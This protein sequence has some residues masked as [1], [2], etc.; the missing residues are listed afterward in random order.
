V[1]QALLFFSQDILKVG[2]EDLV[3]KSS[4]AIDLLTMLTAYVPLS[5]N[6][7][8]KLLTAIFGFGICI[9]VFGLLRYFGY[10]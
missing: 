5:R 10:H 7:G 1:V 4:P 3:F 8:M 9:I 6:A 2:S